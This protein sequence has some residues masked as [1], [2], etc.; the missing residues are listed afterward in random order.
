M[1]SKIAL[2]VVAFIVVTGV[3]LWTWSDTL[4]LPLP[5]RLDRWRDPIGPTQVVEWQKGPET[6]AVPPE[7]RPP[8]VIVILADDL[9]YNDLTFR[10][11]GVGKG[12]MPTPRIDSIAQQGVEFTRGYAG[13]ATC[14]PSRAAIM[15][16]RFPTRFGFEFTPAPKQ[17][18]RLIAYMQ[19][20]TLH[21]PIYHSDREKDVPSIDQ[22]GI[23][24]SEVTMP[25]LLKSQGYRTIML[26]KWH[27]GDAPPMRPTKRGFD[28]FLGFSQ[29]AAM[30]MPQDDPNVVNSVQDFDPIDKFLWANL[31][32]AVRKDD[33]P[34]FEPGGYLTDY[35]ADEA[36]R[37]ID[38]NRNR[39]FFMY[40]AFNAPHTPL[41]ALKSDYDALPQIMNHTER[42]YAGMIRALD[43]GVGKVLDALAKNGLEQNT[44]VIFTSDN[45]GANYI[46]L[47]DI[48]KPYRGWKLTF[49]EGGVHMP[50][51][52]KWPA[53]LAAGTKF[54]GGPVAHVDIFATAAAAAGAALPKDR[55]I[56]GVDLVAL[57]KGGTVDRP[58]FW[59][60]GFY[61]SVLVDGWKLQVSERPE[62]TWLFDLNTDPTEQHDLVAK[63]PDKV[64]E[65][66]AV[67]DKLQSEMVPPAW[68]S[69]I[70]GPTPID[71]PLGVPFTAEDE[72]VSWPN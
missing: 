1:R 48:N 31:S 67:M 36:V 37:A 19:R 49:F 14:A 35:L 6:A 9:G 44:L 40:L 51:F 41:Q 27:L 25:E 56:D 47:P 10:G 7:Q 59:R 39:P 23:P 26:G 30:F 53:K 69:L 54:D 4:L 2:A 33:G 52:A 60:S 5:G 16:G 15:T 32:F 34:R 11:G 17:F 62:K 72:W 28:E 64:A 46:G 50:F 63:R 68:P 8:N 22:M 55:V 13:N 38:A 29:G 61:R 18:M 3:V 45:G 70:D 21:P 20:D 71:H 12:T 57:T 42:V 65:L 66:T 43:R 58:L 24:A